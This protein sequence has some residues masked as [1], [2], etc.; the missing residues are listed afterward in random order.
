MNKATFTAILWVGL[1][2]IPSAFAG[3][4]VSPMI[5]P[6]Q[7]ITYSGTVGGLSEMQANCELQMVINNGGSV[8]YTAELIDNP[9][10]S[11]TIYPASGN[12]TTKGQA[13]AFSAVHQMGINYPFKVSISFTN[14]SSDN[15]VLSCSNNLTGFTWGS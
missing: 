12:L 8:G 7:V 3:S 6:N 5:G 14:K 9:A 1:L 15:I 10:N 13:V 4:D 11:Y 2:E